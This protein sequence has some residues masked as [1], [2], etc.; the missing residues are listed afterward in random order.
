M[1]EGDNVDVGLWLIGLGPGDLQQMTGSA[2]LAAKNADF[3]FL[4]GYTAILAQF[5]H[6]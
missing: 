4:E 2:L 1:T 3:R 6:F 5:S